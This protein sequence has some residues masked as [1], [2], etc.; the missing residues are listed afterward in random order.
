M[1]MSVSMP[2][3]ELIASDDYWTGSL[4]FPQ[5]HS[6]EG[7]LD[8]FTGV[9]VFA[10]N[11]VRRIQALYKDVASN[12]HVCVPI[13][14]G[15]Q[16]PI[17]ERGVGLLRIVEDT[18]TSPVSTSVLARWLLRRAPEDSPEEFDAL[19]LQIENEKLYKGR[20]ARRTVASEGVSHALRIWRQAAYLTGSVSGEQNEGLYSAELGMSPDAVGYL[21]QLPAD[22]TVGQTYFRGK[23]KKHESVIVRAEILKPGGKRAK[24]PKKVRTPIVLPKF[25][26]ANIGTT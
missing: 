19:A 23:N 26:Q 17:M 5:L 21:T 3:H 8:G 16:L 7:V 9:H 24:A 11:G 12:G 15:E 25:S 6:K 18:R 2:P 13:P 14:E 4:P 1:L 10:V 22:I 20:S